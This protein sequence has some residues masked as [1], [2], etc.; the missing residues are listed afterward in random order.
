MKLFQKKF[1]KSYDYVMQKEDQG[2][3]QISWFT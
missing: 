3:I 2:I 1:Y